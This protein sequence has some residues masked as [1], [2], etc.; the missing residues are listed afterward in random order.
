[1]TFGTEKDLFFMYYCGPK[2]SLI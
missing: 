2:G 1:M